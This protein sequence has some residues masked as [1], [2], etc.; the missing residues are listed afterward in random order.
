MARPPLLLG[1]LA[2]VVLTATLVSLQ[3][4]PRIIDG[5]TFEQGWR[6]RI[7]PARYR[8]AGIDT[9]ETRGAKC[10]GEKAL[11]KKAADRLRALLAGKHLRLRVHHAREKYGRQIASVTRGG[12]DVGE[13]LIAEGLARRYDGKRRRSPWCP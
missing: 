11:G 3:M 2:G 6:V 1:A 5:D 7:E 4:P 8:L 13:T 9:P 10:A 12:R